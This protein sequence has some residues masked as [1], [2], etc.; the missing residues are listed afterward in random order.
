[1]P[2]AQLPPNETQRLAALR[3]YDIL[4]T[5]PELAFDRITELAQRLFGVPIVL[6]SLVD[7]DRQWF[8]S[9]VGLGVSQT[10][11]QFAFC[12]HAILSQ[13]PLVV[14]DARLDERF[15]DNPLVTGAPHIRFYCGAVLQTEEGFNLGTLCLIDYSPRDI[16]APDLYNLQDLAAMVVHEIELRQTSRRAEAA[17]QAKS[18]FLANMSHEIRT[19]MN[20]IIGMT[21]LLLDTPLCAEQR[22]L[23][24][25]ISNSGHT[26]LTIIN[27]I[28]D[29][30]K[31]ESGKLDLE[32]EPFDF[33]NCLEGVLGLVMPEATGKGLALICTVEPEVPQVI[34]GDATRLRQVLINLLSNGIKFTPAGEVAVRVASRGLGGSRYELQVAVRDTGIGISPAG[35][36]GLFQSFSQVDTTPTR[37]YG[38]TGLGLAISQRLIHLMGGR[39]WVESQLGQGSTFYFTM[40][41]EQIR[42]APIKPLLDPYPKPRLAER[43]PLRILLAEDNLVNQKVAL[44]ML[45]K[46]GYQADLVVNGLEVLVALENKPYDIL[47]L[48][49]QMPEMD[50][51]ETA[52]RIQQGYPVVQRPRILAMTA[53]AMQG[54]RE[55]CLSVGMDDYLS[56]PIQFQSLHALLEHWGELV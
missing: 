21:D 11:R 19:P 45:Q 18:Q 55:I 36:G 40:E 48:D 32:A 41:V 51:L 26:L 12:A 5:L 52:R 3:S 24:E 8:K 13:E 46:M 14:P 49:V 27:D 44:K 23:V 15:R 50:G 56:K 31:I 54:D 17:T 30:S 42:S 7:Q 35:L 6:V 39:I 16:A 43:L 28:L 9:C 29:F 33:R 38:G 53:N 22:E 1:M 25:T 10:E 47:L 34:L 4:D 37:R 20:G 2:A